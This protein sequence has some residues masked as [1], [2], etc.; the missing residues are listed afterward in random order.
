MTKRTA[1]H[2]TSVLLLMLWAGVMLYFYASGRLAHYLPP[3]GVF[4]PMVLVAGIGLVVLG[5]FNLVTMKSK[6]ADCCSDDGDADGGH[7]HGPG[8]GHDHGDHGHSH[9][10]GHAHAHVHGPGC[11]HD[12]G[13]GVHAEHEHSQKHEKGSGCCGHDHDHGHG[14]S[15]GV[16]AHKHDHDHDHGHHH[17]DHGHDHDHEGHAHGILEESGPVGRLVAIFLLAVPVCYAAILTPDKYSA[18]AV[19]NK[20]LYNQNYGKGGLAEQYSLK[21]EVGNRPAQLVVAGA[22]DGVTPADMPPGPQ[23]AAGKPGDVMPAVHPQELERQAKSGSETKSYGNFTLKDLEA[24]VPRNKDGNFMLEVPEIFYTAGD[25]EVQ[26]VLNGQSV[27]T[28]AQVM[29]EKVNNDAGTRVRI[30]RLQVQCCAAD[31]RP[32]SIPVEFGKAPPPFKDMSW[33]KVIG[34]VTYRQEGN[35]TVPMVEAVSMVE[36]AEPDSKMVY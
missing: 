31:A 19:T 10:H 35:Q 32:Y 11:G 1:I 17:H 8:C 7:V 22:T 23:P 14:H 29:P 26:H 24:Q 2:L 27:E 16:V 21:K 20:G 9:D 12:H 15:H 6:E 30:F 3:D 33:V 5:L 34:K 25:K 28:I 18:H 36:T 4:R 13:N